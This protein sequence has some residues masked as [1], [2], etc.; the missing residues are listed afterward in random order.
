MNVNLSR[1]AAFKD[2]QGPAR[3][4]DVE[5]Y[6]LLADRRIRWNSTEAMI[7]RGMFHGTLHHIAAILTN[8]SS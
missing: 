4:E 7:S 5:V 6:Q 3:G 8:I 1:Q 2:C